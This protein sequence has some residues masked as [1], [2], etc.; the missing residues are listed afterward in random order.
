MSL[1]VDSRFTVSCCFEQSFQIRF[2]D[3]SALLR[4][5]LVKWFL[6]GWRQA[7]GADHER[8]VFNTLEVRLNAAAARDGCVEMTVPMLYLEG[9][10][11]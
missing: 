10:A 6:D 2:M 9:I 8:E 7:V 3:G 11:G 5:S 4:H 1:L